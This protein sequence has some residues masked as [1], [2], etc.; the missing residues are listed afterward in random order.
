MPRN[1]LPVLAAAVAAAFAAACHDTPLR[2]DAPGPPDAMR[3]VAGDGQTAEAGAPLPQP[4]VV[5]LTDRFGRPVAHRA[6]VFSIVSGGGSLRAED[7]ETDATGSVSAFWTLGTSTSESHQAAARLADAQ[8]QPWVGADFHATARPG[9][10]ARVV[11]RQAARKGTVGDPL[12]E[13]LEVSVVDRWGNVV[14]GVEVAWTVTAGGGSV[15]PARSTSDQTGTARATWTLGPR[16]DSAQVAQAALPDGRAE[17]TAIAGLGTGAVL[18]PVA[19][20]GQAAV[21][22][23]RLPEPLRVRLTLADGRPVPGAAVVWTVAAEAGAVLPRVSTTDAAGE[24]AAEVVLGTR[25]GAASVTADAANARAGYDRAGARAVFTAT[26]L[27]G[28]AVALQPRNESAYARPGEPLARP[29][30]VTVSDAY[31]NPVPGVTVGWTVTAGG[32]A[33]DPAASVSDTG[34]VAA[35]RWTMGGIPGPAVLR[36]SSGALAPVQLGATATGVRIVSPVDGGVIPAGCVPGRVWTPCNVGADVYQGSS[37]LQVVARLGDREVS[38]GARTSSCCQPNA[39]YVGALN[40]GGLTPGSYEF[41]V[42][43][44]LVTGDSMAASVPVTVVPDPYPL[45]LAPPGGPAAARA[46]LAECA[47]RVAAS[48]GAPD[49]GTIRPYPAAGRATATHGRR[50]ADDRP[51][52]VT[53]P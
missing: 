45:L 47:A 31:G 41:R 39:M 46:T 22:G 50:T 23:S 18:A 53:C 27:H 20:N 24:A 33:A 36:A 14:A 7:G 32:G 25:A 51:G 35:T 30:A 8:G 34:G 17:F 43:A 40:T 2:P 15:S 5:R 44:V 38:L 29:S 19:G 52:G 49:G 13:P 12:P 48:H 11:A 3:I 21:V 37:L 6:V 10:A 1:R 26:V 16:L 4:L 9:A 28:P 42:T